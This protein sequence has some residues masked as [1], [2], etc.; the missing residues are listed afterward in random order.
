MWFRQFIKNVTKTGHKDRS[1][2]HSTEHDT[3]P[4]AYLISK[5]AVPYRTRG[6]TCCS[7]WSTPKIWSLA[8]LSMTSH[9]TWRNPN[10]LHHSN[11]AQTT[12]SILTRSIHISMDGRPSL[13]KTQAKHNITKDGKTCMTL[14][15]AWLSITTQYNPDPKVWGLSTVLR[16]AGQCVY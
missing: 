7:G 14:M 4:I 5:Q 15:T 8:D 1:H 6:G 16:H 13:T 11:L 10:R 3:H 12:A 9:D 2:L